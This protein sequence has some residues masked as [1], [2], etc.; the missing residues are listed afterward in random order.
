MSSVAVCDAK[1][2]AEYTVSYSIPPGILASTCEIN[3]GKA[4]DGP[5]FSPVPRVEIRTYLLQ[6]ALC[7]GLARTAD[8]MDKQDKRLVKYMIV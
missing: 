8:K 3:E 1:L 2:A 6:V 5:C 7:R 4:F